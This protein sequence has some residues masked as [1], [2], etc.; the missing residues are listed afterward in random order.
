MIQRVG[1]T[2]T[3]VNVIEHQKL[4]VN[5]LLMHIVERWVNLSFA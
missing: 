3:L 1:Q 4:V 5:Q 2:Q